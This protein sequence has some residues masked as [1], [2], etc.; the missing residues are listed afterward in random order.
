MTPSIKYIEIKPGEEPVLMNE[1]LSYERLCEVVGYPV[2]AKNILRGQA[3]V[4]MCEDGK[5]LAL[6][7]NPL[8][9]SLVRGLIHADDFITGTVVV[10]GPADERGQDSSV[11]DEVWAH[12]QNVALKEK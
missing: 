9:T 11:S 5:R 4:Y 3:V 8:A 1:P 6:P 7:Y 10:A 12:V 2:E